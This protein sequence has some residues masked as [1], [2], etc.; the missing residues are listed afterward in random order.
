MFHDSKKELDIRAYLVTNLKSLWCSSV[1]K[2]HQMPV[3]LHKH[4]TLVVALCIL[5]DLNANSF[6]IEMACITLIT[7]LALLSNSFDCQSFILQGENYMSN[8]SELI[9]KKK[10]IVKT[11]VKKSF[12]SLKP[13]PC[14]FSRSTVAPPFHIFNQSECTARQCWIAIGQTFGKSILLKNIVQVIVKKN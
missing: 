4:V 13:R 12:Q 7:V 6:C 9:M 11:I 2:G 14:K 8:Q 5:G 3:S 1:D 10:I